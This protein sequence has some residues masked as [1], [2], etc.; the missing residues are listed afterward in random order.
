[1]KKIF[2][3]SL[4]ALVAIVAMAQSYPE[5]V[6][7]CGP[8][9]PGWATKTWP[10]YT[11]LDA[12]GVPDGTYEWVGDLKEG[13]LKFLYGGDWEPAYVSQTNGEALSEGVHNMGTRI[14]GEDPDNQWAV[15]AGR[16]K[17]TIDVA[18]M[19]LTVADGTGMDAVNGDEQV[20]LYM[21]GDGC[22]TSWNLGDAK[23]LAIT[24]ENIFE[25]DF[26]LTG[27]GEMKFLTQRDFGAALYG[28][29][30]NGEALNGTGTYTL[31]RHE[32]SDDSK[33]AVSLSGTYHF[34]LNLTAGTMVVSNPTALKNVND[35]ASVNKVIENGQLVIL[36]NGVRYNAQ[37]ARF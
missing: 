32:S 37:G 20:F 23:S 28:P 6:Y 2:T 16:Y 8:A 1:M 25:G 21:V 13:S 11:N 31:V 15:T 27:S 36:K 35:N 3:L 18:A 10:M 7:L 14:T 17:L 19:T 24:G 5:R 4:M 33:F 29:A 26:E 22:T 34:V 9:G 12:N 30:T